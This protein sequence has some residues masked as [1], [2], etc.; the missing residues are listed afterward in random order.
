MTR[1]KYPDNYWS[2]RVTAEKNAAR[3]EARADRLEEA[4]WCGFLILYVIAAAVIMGL[5]ELPHGTVAVPV[6]VAEVVF[7]AALAFSVWR[8]DRMDKSAHE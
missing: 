3:K 7:F 8:Y 4:A 2:V 5:K 6:W 1:A